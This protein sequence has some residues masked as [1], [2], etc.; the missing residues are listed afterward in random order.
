[1]NINLILHRISAIIPLFQYWFIDAVSSITVISECEIFALMSMFDK[2]IGMSGFNPTLFCNLFA[3]I[4]TW[5]IVVKEIFQLEDV[6]LHSTFI[7]RSF[8]PR[9]D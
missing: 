9:E 2:L 1:M 4:A 5:R 8:G 6:D 3:G 7:E